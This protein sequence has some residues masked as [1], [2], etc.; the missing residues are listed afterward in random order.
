[1]DH[2]SLDSG[3]TG[4]TLQSEAEV[5]RKREK[6]SPIIR[7]NASHRFSV[8]M[9]DLFAD[10]APG[11]VEDRVLITG[12]GGVQL[13]QHNLHTATAVHKAPDVVHHGSLTEHAG[14][15]VRRPGVNIHAHTAL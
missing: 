14:A 7:P 4:V 1:M 12:H 5:E 6:S 11:V 13:L 9:T 15:M 8:I 2:E 10:A 3:T